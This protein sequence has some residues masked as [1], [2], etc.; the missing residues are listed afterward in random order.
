M[1]IMNATKETSIMLMD[2]T[3]LEGLNQD[4]FAMME[5]LGHPMSVG[6]GAEMAIDYLLKNVMITI[7]INS[8][9]I[10]LQLQLSIST[11]MLVLLIQIAMDVPMSVL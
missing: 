3:S 7:W 11:Q 4:G 1:A 10:Q 8:M 5:G 2:V 6:I 9:E